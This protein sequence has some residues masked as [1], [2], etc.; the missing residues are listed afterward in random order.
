MHREIA[1][2]AL[3]SVQ[4]MTYCGGMLRGGFVAALALAAL[5][6]L[7]GCIDEGITL[8]KGT[9]PPCP[10]SPA[11]ATHVEDL[12]H[13][14][15]DLTGAN[16]VFPDGHTLAAPPPGALTSQEICHAKETPNPKGQ[17][18][19]V[20]TYYAGNLGAWGAV[21]WIKSAN[22]KRMNYWGT[23]TAVKKEKALK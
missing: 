3:A 18:V 23:P 17:T 6:G 1:R 20:G 11:P 10:T 5:L 8:P 14:T 16:L 7:T 22:G 13:Q 2:A 9:L 15:C 19:C 4:S 12:S 21:A